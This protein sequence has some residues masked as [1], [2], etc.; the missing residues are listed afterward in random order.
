MYQFF[1]NLI[2]LCK[3]IV[4]VLYFRYPARN[5]YVIG[6]TGTSG[7][8]STSHILYEILHKAGEKVS[9][10]ST[11]EAMIDGKSVDTGFH[12]TTPSAWVLQKMM[13]TAVQ[14][15]SK[16]FILEVT[17]HAL[18]QFRTFGCHLQMAVITN[19]THEHIDYHKTFDK[20]KHTKAKILSGVS[21]G[22]LNN[23]D[24]NFEYLKGRSSG[25]IITYGMDERS[26][27]S[28]QKLKLS[29]PIP[30]KY[31]I[32]NSLA[33]YSAAFM[34][35]IKDSTIKNGIS[36]FTGVAGRLEEIATGKKFRIFIDFAHKPD[37]LQQVL[38]TLR[39][40]CRNKLIVIFGC[41]GLRDHKKRQMMGKIAAEFADYSV[42]TAEDP[43]TEDVREII[44]EIAEGFESKGVK[45]K[46]KK[47][48]NYNFLLSREK[49]FWEIPDRQEAINFGIRKIAQTGDIVVTCGKGHEKSMCYGKTEYPWDEKRAI[50]KALYATIQKA[51][52]I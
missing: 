3:S 25:K 1:K 26:D 29:V 10:I 44:R 9:M 32:Y 18:D 15:K 2:H 27:F 48:K 36:K 19:I 34:I 21:I 50:Q 13:S 41:A 51:S 49:Y 17:S 24:K 33:A 20:Y 40:L 30:G 22:I 7:K 43:R 47:I 45:K 5:L 23:D 12:V 11:V 8:T 31:N 52:K 42:L 14:K 39:D 28:Y 4:A 6:I 46:D 35:G 38:L 37:A 16:Y